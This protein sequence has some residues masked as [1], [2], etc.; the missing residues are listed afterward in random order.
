MWH[1]P[2][3]PLLPGPLRLELELNN[4]QELVCYK[5]LEVRSVH[6]AVPAN[7]AEAK[8][9]QKPHEVTEKGED[10]NM[11]SYSDS[12]MREITLHDLLYFSFYYGIDLNYLI[13][14]VWGIFY[15]ARKLSSCFAH[16]Y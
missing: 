16:C 5:T 1:T 6:S 15:E 8:M 7:K 10:W 14:L 13:L 12:K 3:L 4:L 11:K 2:S 9:L